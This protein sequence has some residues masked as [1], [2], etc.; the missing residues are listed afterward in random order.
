MEP[1]IHPIYIY[2]IGTVGEIKVAFIILSALFAVVTLTFSLG[3]LYSLDYIKFH[4]GIYNKK[5]KRIYRSIAVLAC[6]LLITAIIP[7]KNTA[8]GMAVASQI[9]WNRVNKTT[10]ITRDLS[11]EIKLTVIEIIRE[12]KDQEKGE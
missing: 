2:L 5:L 7:T 1:V 6:S 12:I 10:E 9:T 8:I 4:D 3:F 11:K